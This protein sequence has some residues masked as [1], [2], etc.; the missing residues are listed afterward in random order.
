MIRMN[1]QGMVNLYVISKILL[2]FCFY[3]Q[4]TECVSAASYKVRKLLHES[5]LE[6]DP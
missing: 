3:L 5:G 4:F 6:K 1:R 2:A